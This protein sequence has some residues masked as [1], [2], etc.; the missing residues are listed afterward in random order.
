MGE[1]ILAEF[2]PFGWDE[3]GTYYC[4]TVEIYE[5]GFIKYV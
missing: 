1:L 3:V 4:C 5:N 2:E